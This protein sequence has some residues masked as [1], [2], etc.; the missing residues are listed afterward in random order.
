MTVET[1]L[2]SQR[3]THYSSQISPEMDGQKTIIMGWVL[4]VREHGS[5][6]FVTIKD[7]DGEI[8]IVAKKGN[9]PDEVREEIATLKAHSS[10][11]ISG[12]I[13]SSQKSPFG[14]E[15]IPDQIRVFSKVQKVPPFEP[16]AKTVKNIDTRLE[17]RSID[18]RRDIL[19]HTFKIRSHVLHAIRQYFVDDGFTEISTPKIISS[20]TEG[21]AALFSIFYYDKQAF[22]AQSPQLYKEQLTMS[23]EK[24]FEIAP[25][26]RAES[27]RT[28]RHL[29]EAIS[30]DL[31]EAFVDYNDVMDR[32]ESILKVSANAA[33][34]YMQNIKGNNNTIAIPNIPNKIP[35][36]TY[37]DLLAQ[38]QQ[39]G[40]KAQWGDDLYPSDLK[41]LGLD[42]FYFIVDWPLGPKPFYV[43]E[44]T[45]NKKYQ[46]TPNNTKDSK[47][48]SESFDL[49]YGELEISSGSTR[50]EKREELEAQLKIKG[51]NVDSFEYH[52]GAFEYGVPPH[53]GCGIGLERLMMA[54]T[55]TEN[56]RD[57]TFYPRDVD[58]LVP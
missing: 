49:M 30:I 56:I 31:E 11:A 9:C 54:L 13:K 36:Y 22:L 12:T 55:G 26:F 44:A 35:R 7:K 28:Q 5:I 25:I 34:T 57:A 50:I 45:L 53:A 40:S 3:R 33:K 38:I 20:A 16:V 41:K 51:M 24:V 18:L 21:G 47:R 4:T 2:G 19:Q 17:V 10:I 15:I 14:F 29:S 8:P 42:G 52:L 32:I 39:K 58:R 48:I 23:F 43:K 27:S 37:Q 46:N 1:S 6:T